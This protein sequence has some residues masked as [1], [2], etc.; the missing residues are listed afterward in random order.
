ME[1]ELGFKIVHPCI[2][3]AIRRSHRSQL[4]PLFHHQSASE[5]ENNQSA[6]KKKI[7]NQH[8]RR[9]SA[10]SIETKLSISIRK[11][12]S[13]ISIKVK[14]IINQHRRR[15]SI[16]I[17]KR[18]FISFKLCTT[19]PEQKKGHPENFMIKIRPICTYALIYN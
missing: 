2:W 8:R 14:K 3:S 7:I 1:I 15:K 13:S 16:S 10:I 6:K 17:G 9:K 12:K 4:P 5:K 11:R 18:M 19:F